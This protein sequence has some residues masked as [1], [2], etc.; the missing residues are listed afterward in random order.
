MPKT[1][2][3][4]KLV[5]LASKG[6]QE[7]VTDL[8]EQLGETLLRI[9]PKCWLGC[10]IPDPNAPVILVLPE[11]QYVEGDAALKGRPGLPRALLTS[12]FRDLDERDLHTAAA[13]YLYRKPRR[14]RRRRSL[15]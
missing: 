10:L 15:Q 5:C 1:I 7:P 4:I 8:V 9:E 6:L 3:T 12:R 11:K 2:H 14:L 13:H